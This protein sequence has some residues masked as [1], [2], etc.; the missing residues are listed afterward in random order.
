MVAFI[1]RGKVVADL[2]SLS[3]V[4]SDVCRRKLLLESV[5]VGLQT[6]AVL[7]AEGWWFGDEGGGGRGRGQGEGAG[8]GGGHESGH[9]D[10]TGSH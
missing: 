9:A 5:P 2:C 4:T 8:V 1:C 3:R 10:R 6:F 7:A